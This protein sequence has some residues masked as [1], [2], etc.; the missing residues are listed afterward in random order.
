MCL[1]TCV[2]C[3]LLE[4]IIVNKLNSHLTSCNILH[5]A[6]HGF[7]KGRSTFTNLL[8]SL[9][10]WT[11][12]LQNKEQVDIVYID[13]SKA[14]DVVIHDKLFTRLY[15]YGIRGELLAWLKCLYTGRTHCTKVGDVLSEEADMISG[16]IQGSVIGP[17]M[18]LVFIN[19]LTEILDS[20]GINVKFFA[21]D[22]KL[23]VKIVNNIDTVTL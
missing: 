15:S 9:N 14:F 18:F 4:R 12:C 3:K 23:Y 22:A 19:E 21:D 1:F 2:S 16:V 8:E 20:F 7:I 17:M 11:L 6:Q 13:F 5:V 10:E